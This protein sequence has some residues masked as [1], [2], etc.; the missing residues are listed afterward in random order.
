MSAMRPAD[1]RWVRRTADAAAARYRG[2]GALHALGFAADA[3]PMSEGTP[4]AKVLRV[5]R[6]PAHASSPNS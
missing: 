4:F 1:D 5:A 6:K 3:V 2:A